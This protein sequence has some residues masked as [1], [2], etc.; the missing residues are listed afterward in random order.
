M[1]NLWNFDCSVDKSIQ[2]KDFTK[3]VSASVELIFIHSYIQW[4]S[5]SHDLTFLISKFI[6]IVHLTF[7]SRNSP[8]LKL[9]IMALLLALWHNIYFMPSHILTQS[10]FNSHLIFDGNVLPFWLGRQVKYALDWHNVKT[11]NCQSI[12]YRAKKAS[13]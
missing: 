13:F 4:S 11:R 2:Q 1:Y 3:R 12:T 6:S 5:S 7:E 8:H 9:K 10:I